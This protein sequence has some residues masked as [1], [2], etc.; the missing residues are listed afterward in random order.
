MKS[1]PLAALLGCL[2]L[3]ACISIPE[4]EADV[5]YL[6]LQLTGDFGYQSNTTDQRRDGGGGTAIRQ[7]I[8]SAFGLGDRQGSVYGRAQ[9]DLGTPLLSLSAFQFQEQ[10][11]GVL[12]ADF[13]SGLTQG[14]PVHSD[15]D[16]WS[17]K[18]ALAFDI[19]LG[20]VAVSPGL[21]VDYLSLDM[22][23]QDVLG[24]RTE[25]L[26]FDAPIPLLF[27]RGAVDLGVL[28]GVAEV[29]YL[30]L[31]IED[32]RAKVLDVEA[33]L[34]YRPWSVLD[35]FAGYRLVQFRG[36]GEIDGDRADIDIGLAGFLIGGGIVF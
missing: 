22:S 5:G 29:G 24:I 25:R 32:V 13:G 36:R 6:N 1:L 11:N 35:L 19:E 10:G 28:K 8:E 7:D 30:E 17:V 31:D 3:P 20:P 4:L 9:L 26:R 18:A 21:A 34:H 27:L 12:Q 16:L 15:L 2:G 23:V 14:T 33:R